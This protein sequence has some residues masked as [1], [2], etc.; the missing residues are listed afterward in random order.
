MKKSI[1]ITESQYNRIFLN[2]Q[3]NTPKEY[4]C[5]E[6]KYG[7]KGSVIQ[8][9]TR[10]SYIIKNN[11][12]DR[13]YFLED[14]SFFHVKKGQGWRTEGQYSC[15]DKKYKIKNKEGGLFEY[16]DNFLNSLSQISKLSKQN[17]SKQ[18]DE[19]KNTGSDECYKEGYLLGLIKGIKSQYLTEKVEFTANSG[20]SDEGKKIWNSG[21]CYVC[22]KYVYD[23]SI[24]TNICY[25]ENRTYFVET[26]SISPKLKF[27]I[28]NNIRKSSKL[29]DTFSTSYVSYVGYWNTSY[30]GAGDIEIIVP[31]ISYLSL[32]AYKDNEGNLKKN[33]GGYM[34]INRGFKKI[35]NN[36]LL[37]IEPLGDVTNI[38][39]SKENEKIYND[40]YDELDEF[41]VD[42][43]D[44]LNVLNAI[45]TNF[46]S[47]EE[48]KKFNGLVALSGKENINEK[49]NDVTI[50]G[51]EY[52]DVIKPKLFDII[53]RNKLD[54][55]KLSDVIK[56]LESL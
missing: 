10:K 4:D 45:K 53:E 20:I 21:K 15:A 46:N 56:S 28:N 3:S 39:L 18:N 54:W 35:V 50:F 43:G 31:D 30:K 19:V 51:E 24:K 36:F 23:T 17:T 11:N 26:Y 38:P 25:S 40:L 8:F 1:K 33:S 13:L 12:N 49:I 48:Y 5:I 41:V 9:D 6:E 2:E 16:I 44:L 34:T 32:I 42:K 27:R 7:D 52:V 55:S 14:K 47:F 37:D 22:Y 29:E